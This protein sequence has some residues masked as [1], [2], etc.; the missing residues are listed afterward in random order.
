MLVNFVHVILV[1]CLIICV[2]YIYWLHRGMKKE[3]TITKK[4]KPGKKI[5]KIKEE[6]LEETESDE[7]SFLKSNFDPSITTKED[8]QLLD[9]D[10]DNE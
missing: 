1:L 7:I 8:D 5:K 3:E 4:N 9:N 2:G 6:E 10:N